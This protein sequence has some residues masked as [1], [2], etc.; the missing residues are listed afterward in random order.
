MKPKDI[1]GKAILKKQRNSTDP[2]D[3]YIRYIE[4]SSDDKSVMTA[5]VELSRSYSDGLRRYKSTKNTEASVLDAQ[6]SGLEGIL[7]ACRS[8]VNKIYYKE[9]LDAPIETQLEEISPQLKTFTYRKS[10][11]RMNHIESGSKDYF[12]F[13][14]LAHE[15]LT[16]LSIDTI[17]YISGGGLEAACI[18][19]KE[20][21]CKSIV[22]IIYSR[23]LHKDTK[24]T[25]PRVVDN[26]IKNEVSGKNVLVVDDWIYEGTTMEKALKFVASFEPANLYGAAVK[27]DDYNHIS[28]TTTLTEL[29]NGYCLHCDRYDKIFR[30]DSISQNN[31]VH[32]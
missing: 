12:D 17:V 3:G 27:R 7:G 14:Q 30:V 1:F 9:P 2:L 5:L 24:V 18:A 15:V 6:K 16:R 25:V 13:K 31:K 11:N 8:Y 29:R 19:A 32:R 22:P 20:T 23:Y 4:K 28:G 10:L 21:H 26:S